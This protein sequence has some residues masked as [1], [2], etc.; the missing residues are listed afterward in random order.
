M[1]LTRVSWKMPCTVIYVSHTWRIRKCNW[2]WQKIKSSFR[3]ES[4]CWAAL[5]YF[6]NGSFYCM[7]QLFK[8][9]VK[10]LKNGVFSSRFFSN[11]TQDFNCYPVTIPSTKHF[12][13]THTIVE[14]MEN[15]YLRLT[16]KLHFEVWLETDSRIW[17][18][19][20]IT[21][22]KTTRNCTIT[23]FWPSYC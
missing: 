4:T 16:Q 19:F 21:T 13:P 8:I 14:A 20:C 9:E 17:T 7:K 23:S 10:F 6:S 1:R 11:T 18:L 22:C 3:N 2:K 5:T 15:V 12:F